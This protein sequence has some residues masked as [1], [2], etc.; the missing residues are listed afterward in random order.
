MNIN[1]HEVPFVRLVIPLIV[2]I[3]LSITLDTAIPY[4]WTVISLLTLVILLLFF[5][6]RTFRN[7]RLIPV[8]MG[9]WLLLFG[10]QHCFEYNELRTNDHFSH[11]LIKDNI[12]AS[13]IL[14]AQVS[15]IPTHDKWTK[16]QA[17][18]HSKDSSLASGNLLIYLHR[19]SLSETLAYGDIISVNSYLNKVESP[20]NPYQFNYQSYLHYKNIHYQTFVS[21]EKKWM[22]SERGQGN[23]F[24]STIFNWRS[25][26]LSILEN[27]L[28]PE[29]YSVGAALILGYR[30]ALT[31]E[32][33]TAYADTGAIHVLAVSGLHVGIIAMILNYI[34][35]LFFRKRHKITI[36][37]IQI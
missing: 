28:S 23:L 6:K 22:I 4:S 19:D 12:K 37:V 34:L 5:K 10:Y 16:F 14:L 32:V 24:Y 1:W 25:K 20:K 27:N 17:I 29:S 7:A 35:G 26:C 11:L 36:G 3:I 8:L 30:E 31:E 21:S 2:G 33:Q 15:E 9:F 18:I 13:S